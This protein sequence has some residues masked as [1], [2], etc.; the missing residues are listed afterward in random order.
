MIKFNPINFNPIPFN[1]INF[2]VIKRNVINLNAINFGV[3]KRNLIN[4][5]EINFNEINFSI[6][7]LNVI[8]FNEVKLNVINCNSIKLNV[9]KFN[10]TLMRSN[11]MQLTLMHLTAFTEN[12]EFFF[13]F[14]FNEFRRTQVG[15]GAEGERPHRRGQNGRPVAQVSR[16]AR[17]GGQV[18]QG[19]RRDRIRAPAQDQEGVGNSLADRREG[20]Q[21]R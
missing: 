7:R 6:R 10:A 16:T 20:R 4:F 12:I 5:N 1:G 19:R 13:E 11:V 8:N 3:I 21:Q 18:V 17:T 9:I 2:N 15:D 14:F